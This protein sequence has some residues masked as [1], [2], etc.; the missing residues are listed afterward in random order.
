VEEPAEKRTEGYTE[1]KWWT[2]FGP[3]AGERRAGAIPGRPPLPSR[4]AGHFPSAPHLPARRGT[5]SSCRSLYQ[6]VRA[7]PPHSSSPRSRGK[8]SLEQVGY[9]LY[10]PATNRQLSMRCSARRLCSLASVC[11][12]LHG[13][14][15]QGFDIG[16]FGYFLDRLCANRSKLLLMM[17]Q[18]DA[19]AD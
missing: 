2:T 15:Q 1:A 10:L 6:E 13:F 14:V 8:V 3:W 5:A 9:W 7:Y 17:Q 16:V 12:D 18:K 11:C 19:F 4:K